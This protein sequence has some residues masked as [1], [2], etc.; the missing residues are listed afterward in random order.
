MDPE[1][2]KSSSARKWWLLIGGI[3]V[4]VVVFTLL[5]SL[6]RT[7][8]TPSAD[9][10]TSTGNAAAVGS[11]LRPELRRLDDGAIEIRHDFFR[12]A[13]I[14]LDTEEEDNAL[15][16]CLSQGIEQTFGEG[17]EDWDRARVW[18]ETQRIQNECMG[19]PGIPAPPRPPRPARPGN[20]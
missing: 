3:V 8:S 20:S 4:F 7:D 11:P 10:P 9:G 1:S 2:E 6:V 14:R 19:L 18:R 16:D 5:E 15:F 17:T 13:T 12:R